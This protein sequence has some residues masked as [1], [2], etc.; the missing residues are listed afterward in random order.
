MNRNWSERCAVLLVLALT[1]LPAAQAGEVLDGV[2]SREQLRCG[3]SEGIP[4]FSERDAEGRWRGLDVDFCRAVAAAVLGDA[5][6]VELV[7]LR[8]ST[9]FPALQSRKVD[10]LLRNTTWTLTREAVL[11]V[12]FPGILFYDGQGF[13]VRAE[14]GIDSL[15]DLNGASVCVEKGTTHQRNLTTY[16]EV[17]GWSVEPLVIDSAPDAAAAFFAGRCRAYTSDAGQLAAMRSLAQKDP[18]TYPILPERI[19]REP[20]SAVVWGGDPEWT[21]VVRWVL[22]VL[23]LA[24]EYG[25]TAENLKTVLARNRNLLVLRTEDERG[26]IARSLEIEPGWGIRAV[27]AVGNYGEIYERHLGRDSP[28]KIDRG[29][30]RLWT[31]GG[32]HYVPPID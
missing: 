9:R 29:L 12:Q 3:V 17:Q 20:L 10:L 21:T 25:I 23:I 14:D 11:K 32:L 7:P 22:N 8:A 15:A 13:M 16:F 2:K 31:E 5:D 19:S 26:I 6:K 28:L 24:E 1:V 27:Q 4:G 18:Q 30:N